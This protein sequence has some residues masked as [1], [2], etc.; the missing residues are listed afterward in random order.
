MTLT[1]NQATYAWKSETGFQ[2][3]LLM[4]RFQRKV[5]AVMEDVLFVVVVVVVCCCCCCFHESFIGPL[6]RSSKECIEMSV[7]VLTLA[8]PNYFSLDTV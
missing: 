8:I 6:S 7:P 2:A 3:R 1:L 4:V 5:K